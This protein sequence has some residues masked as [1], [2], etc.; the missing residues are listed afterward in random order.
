MTPSYFLGV[1]QA[2]SLNQ[3]WCIWLNLIVGFLSI[4]WQSLNWFFY[5]VIQMNIWIFEI[6]SNCHIHKKA[7]FFPAMLAIRFFYFN[8]GISAGSCF[9][10][11]VPLFLHRVLL[12]LPKSCYINW[13]GQLFQLQWGKP[14]YFKILALRR[15][16]ETIP[17]CNNSSELVGVFAQY[18]PYTTLSHINT[19]L[20]YS[21]IR[22]FKFP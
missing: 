9:S 19:L 12:H 2:C 1:W 3:E 17:V 15:S 20:D 16:T 6:R 11:D 21:A 4:K 7:F 14:C 8:C 22:L 5:Y 18:I 10:L 13:L